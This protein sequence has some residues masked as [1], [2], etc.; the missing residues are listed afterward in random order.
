MD[1]DA[2]TARRSPLYRTSDLA[3]SAF[4]A[5]ARTLDTVERQS[6]GRV[7]FGFKDDQQLQ[8]DVHDFYTMGGSVGPLRYSQ[9][10]QS[11]KR[12][13]HQTLRAPTRTEEALAT[14]RPDKAIAVPGATTVRRRQRER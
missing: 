6:D 4:L 10:L 12:L 13:V 11:L 14:S 7:V 2:S 3:L 8:D 1:H 9:A 5:V